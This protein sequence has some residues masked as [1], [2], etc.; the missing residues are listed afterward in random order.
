MKKP[1]QYLSRRQYMKVS[2]GTVAAVNFNDILCL[3][4][5]KVVAQ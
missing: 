2:V 3:V 4:M 5:M 1:D